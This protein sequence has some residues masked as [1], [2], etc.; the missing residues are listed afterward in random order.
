MQTVNSQD[1]RPP[2]IQPTLSPILGRIR[3]Q[4]AETIRDFR[5]HIDAKGVSPKTRSTYIEAVQGFA[6][7]FRVTALQIPR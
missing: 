4:D 1:C 5:D 7:I 6:P 3:Q 2:N